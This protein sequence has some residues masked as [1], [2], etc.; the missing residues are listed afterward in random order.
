MLDKVKNMKVEEK[1]KYCFTLVVIIASISGVLGLVFLFYNNIQYKT[2]LVNNGFSQGDIGAFSTDLN[3]EAILIREIIIFKDE[4]SMQAG[5]KQLEDAKALTNEA[6]ATMKVHCNTAKEV[7]YL[8]TIDRTLSQYRE[9]YGQ[10]VEL[11]LAGHDDEAY[12]MMVD[13][14]KP[15]LS[16]LTNAMDSLMALNVT[17]GND[18]SN[19]LQIQ[20][21]IIVG[22]MVIVVI[23]SIIISMRIASFVAKLF[24]DPIMKVKDAS[25]KLA[26]GDLKNIAIEKLYPDEIGDMTDSFKEAIEMLKSYI[27]DLDRVLSNVAEGNFNITT[28]ADFKGDFVA[29]DNAISTITSSLSDTLGRINEASEQVA[30]GA[31]QMAESAQALAEG[32]TDQAGSVEELTATIQ[33]VTEA[34]VNSSKKANQSYINAQEFEELAEK[35]NEDIKHLNTAMERINDTSTQIA[36]I[37]AEIEDIASQTNLLSLNAS[38]EAARAGE[39]GRGFAVVADQIG[40][41]A[42]DSANSA[43]NTKKLIENS[44]SEIETGNEITVKATTAIESVI[45]G[46]KLLASSTRE[47]SD[48]SEAQADAMRQLELGVEQISE[49]I[50]SNSAAAQ[51][52]SATSEELSAQS[53]NLEQLVRQFQLKV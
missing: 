8:N 11:A 52:T 34:V 32:A 12:D 2:A 45:N 20:T 37:I 13:Q 9:I 51:E 24:A 4:T 7:D 26:Q 38:I 42:S 3:K 6:Y 49:V 5:A 22:I 47:I 1:L 29:L 40:K 18:V 15:V 50:Q 28:E 35:S 14:G 16:E 23:I 39:A 31:G 36:N 48:L 27:N 10:V 44:I 19:R 33:N 53:E 25:A 21:Y 30:L 46:I 43:I 17:M 41:L